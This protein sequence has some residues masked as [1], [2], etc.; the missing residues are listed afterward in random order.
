MTIQPTKKRIEWIDSLKGVAA[1]LV[2]VSHFWETS[3]KLY[4]FAGNENI[5]FLILNDITINYIDIGKIAVTIFFMISGYLTDNTFRKKTKKQF[6]I[7]RCKRM[8]PLYWFSILL[9]LILIGSE[10]ISKIIINATMFQQF[11]GVENIIGAFWTLQIDWIFYII[12]LILVSLKIFENKKFINL[13]YYGLLALSLCMAILRF[14]TEKNFPVAIGILLSVTFLGL[15]LKRN[16]TDDKDQKYNLRINI[17]LF[18]IV[19]FPTVMFSYTN[20]FVDMQVGFRYYITYLLA[21]IIFFI[22][23][24]I[25]TRK[26]IFSNL[27][28]YSYSLYLL[29]PTIGFF[30]INKLYDYFYCNIIINMI[31][32]F[33]ITV[34][35]SMISGKYIEPIWVNKKKAN[36][37]IYINGRFLTQKITGVQRYAI[38]VLK[39]LDKLNLDYHLVLLAPKRGI[40]QNMKLKNIELRQIG[41]FTGHIWEQISLPIYIITHQRGKLLNFCNVAPI[42]YPG[43]VTIHDIAF[44]THPE[45][46]NKKFSIIY[47]IITRLNINRYKHIFTVSEFS[48]KEILDNYKI[49]ADKI[50]VT[51]NSAEHIKEIKEDKKIIDKLGLKDKKFCFSLG[52]KSP[53]KNHQFILQCAEKN[54]DI[55]FVISGDENKIFK[56]NK[57][58]NKNKN[59]IYTGYLSDNELISLYKNCTCFIFPSLYEGFGIPPLEAI[60]VGCKKVLLS[61][62]EVFKEIYGT[63]VEYFDLK[64]NERYNIKKILNNGKAVN[65]N[66]IKKYSWQ[67]ITKKIMENVTDEKNCV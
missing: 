5:L 10:P 20:K 56:D 8:Y 42:L 53:H 49:N 3:K 40:I 31:I 55:L 4:G 37:I 12:C 61:N 9:S 17:M 21:F 36:K 44:K 63:S 39:Q 25:V 26:T 2:I 35:C 30:V 45:H 24:K 7:D 27:G 57:V 41:N 58:I 38:E 28:K 14:Y 29:H 50:T 59:I 34:I 1:I 15:M 23:K 66:V 64:D 19:L 51:Y 43:Y 67:E 32:A 62:I 33:I 18:F 6:I 46:L 47:R 60:T 16:E 13:S 54:P 22:G 65:R 11:V 48:K 52:S